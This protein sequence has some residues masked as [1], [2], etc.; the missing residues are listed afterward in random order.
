MLE[1]AFAQ[2]SPT[3]EAEHVLD[4]RNALSFY[5]CLI[6]KIK[7]HRR[8]RVKKEDKFSIDDFNTRL[9]LKRIEAE[10][11]HNNLPKLREENE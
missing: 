9:K 5:D 2:K 7:E 4:D 8:F 10:L 1:I 3:M 11:E 6:P